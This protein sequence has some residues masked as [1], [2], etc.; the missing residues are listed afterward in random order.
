MS[1]KTII[2]IGI[3]LLFIN[4]YAQ[5]TLS[6]IS[7][8]DLNRDFDFLVSAITETHPDPYSVISKD[9]FESQVLGI[10]KNFKDSLTLKKYY[11]LISPFVASLQDGHTSLKFPGRKLFGASDNLF[12]FVVK[13]NIEK[14]YLV[15]TENLSDDYLQIPVGAEILTINRASAEEIIQKIIEN[16]SGESRAYRLKMGTDFNAFAFV[17]GAF[18]DL[19]GTVH[20]KYK[21]ENEVFEKVIP[22]VRFSNLMEIVKSKQRKSADKTTVIEIPDFSLVIKPEI[23]TAILEIRYFG[24]DVKY[25]DFLKESFKKINEQ[26]IKRVVIDIRENGGGNSSS[27]DELLKYLA[28][29]PFRQFDQ[30]LVKY[31]QLQKDVYEGYCKNDVQ[32]C[33]TYDYIRTK[34]NGDIETFLEKG[35]ISPYGKSERFSGEVYLLTSTRT[36]SSA[37]NFAQAFKHYKIGKIIGEETGGRVVSYGDRISVD[38][39]VSRIP[40]SISTKKFY[41]VGTSEKDMHGVEV[42]VEVRAEKALDYILGK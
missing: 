26:K 1:F 16:T 21:F 29:Q 34:N 12:P 18:Y 41:T 28:K 8:E 27:G 40:L 38:L 13:S 35:L 7:K 19:E 15:V 31:S 14:P 32:Y 36:F 37:M 11:Q 42:N 25:K 30:T 23:K 10:K 17:F 39:P 9:K 4:T 2:T 3:T 22:T 5:N 24:D 33:T 6:Y 20:I